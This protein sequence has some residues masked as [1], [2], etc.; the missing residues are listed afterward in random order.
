CFAIVK[1]AGTNTLT[2][3]LLPYFAYA[4]LYGPLESVHLPEDLLTGIPGL[5]KSLIL[6]LAL[7]NIAGLLSKYGVRLKL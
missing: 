5:I 7:V 6:A 3:Y 2:C 1:P 4:F